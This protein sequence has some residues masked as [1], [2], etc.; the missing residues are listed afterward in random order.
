LPELLE[1]TSCE[2]A[3]PGIPFPQ[4]DEARRVIDVIDAAAAGQGRRSEIAERYDFNERQADY[5]ANAAAFLGFLRRTQSG[6]ELSDLGQRFAVLP[7]S[8]RQT[9]FLCQI[10]RRPVFREAMQR[11]CESGSLPRQEEIAE[12]VS[13]N[14]GLTGKT[15]LRRARTVLSWGRWLEQLLKTDGLPVALG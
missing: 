13:K 8:E 2:E 10:A 5:Y 7:F 12:L 11:L 9:L 14:T 4:A 3:T 6:F 15:P 1:A